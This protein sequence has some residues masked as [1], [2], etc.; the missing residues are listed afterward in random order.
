MSAP[1]IVMPA[2]RAAS[3]SRRG[4]GLGISSFVLSVITGFWV[5]IMWAVSIGATQPG[6]ARPI[7][8]VFFTL[9]AIIG[10]VFLTLTTITATF[11]F[12]RNLQVGRIWAVLAS[13][14]GAIALTAAVVL[15][16]AVATA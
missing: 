9:C 2:E 10:F 15:A 1:I 5:I 11:S 13:A 3:R 8:I 12:R 4:A 14:I 7:A 6:S 16:V